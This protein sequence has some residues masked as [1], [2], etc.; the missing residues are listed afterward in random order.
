MFTYVCS[1]V[2][3][4]IATCKRPVL[5]IYRYFTSKHSHNLFI[6]YC[7][8]FASVA[9]FSSIVQRFKMNI[10]VRVLP[11]FTC[12]SLSTSPRLVSAVVK[13]FKYFS[14]GNE[15]SANVV[16]T[17]FFCNHDVKGVV[18]VVYF[19]CQHHPRIAKELLE[20]VVVEHLITG[21]ISVFIS[22]VQ[23]M[24][25]NKDVLKRNAFLSI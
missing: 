10:Y 2:I 8:L 3:I 13:C 14:R 18:Y 21:L 20:C 12:V 7:L 9:V 11:E 16:T 1:L 25:L 17:S 19:V 5:K 15:G 6:Y 4:Q 23:G 22:R 24:F